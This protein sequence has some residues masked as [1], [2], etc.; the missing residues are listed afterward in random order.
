M[1]VEEVELVL[2]NKQFLKKLED[3]IE[4]GKDT[5]YGFNGEDEIAY[6]IFLTHDAMSAV[7]SVLR[8]TLVKP[9]R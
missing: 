2:K 8:E 4:Q 3:A 5:D 6:D 7:L 9:I 1:T